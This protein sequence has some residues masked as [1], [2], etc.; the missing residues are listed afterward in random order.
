MF[1]GDVHMLVSLA[2]LFAAVT[3]GPQA[4]A[5][6]AA[7]GLDY[8]VTQPPPPAAAANCLHWVSDPQVPQTST[9]KGLDA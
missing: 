7:T 4:G 1:T 9:V 6:D 2:R 8:H 5:S 3:E